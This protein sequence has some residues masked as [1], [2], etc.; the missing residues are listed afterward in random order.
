MAWARLSDL[1]P[2]MRLYTTGIECLPKKDGYPVRIDDVGLFVR[3]ECAKHYLA[4]EVTKSNYLGTL[5]GFSLDPN[6]LTP[7]DMVI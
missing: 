7:Y 5:E 6:N 4:G 3:C 2:G 1:R